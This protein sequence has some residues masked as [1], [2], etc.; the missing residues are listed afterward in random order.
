MEIKSPCRQICR[1]D[2]NKVCVGCYRTMKEIV[3]WIDYT[4]KQKLEVWKKIGKRRKG[5]WDV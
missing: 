4:D 5:E 3:G 2:E 1:Y